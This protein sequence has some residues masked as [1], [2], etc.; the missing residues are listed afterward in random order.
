M[1]FKIV[2]AVEPFLKVFAHRVLSPWKGNHIVDSDLR[3]SII[4]WGFVS[5]QKILESVQP[6][7][8]EG[9]VEKRAEQLNLD[10]VEFLRGTEQA[11]RCVASL[12]APEP[13][14]SGAIETGSADQGSGSGSNSEALSDKGGGIGSGIAVDTAALKAEGSVQVA[15]SSVLGGGGGG[16]KPPEESRTNFLDLDVASPEMSMFLNDV[17]ESYRLQGLVPRLSISSVQASLCN[18]GIRLGGISKNT[19]F[20][21]FISADEVKYH[22]TMGMLGPEGAVINELE[23]RAPQRVIADVKLTCKEEFLLEDE[24]GEV[25]H[26]EA[27]EEGPKI[28][29]LTL[30]S[31]VGDGRKLQWQITNINDV[32]KPN[33]AYY[34]A[35]FG[36]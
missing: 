25:V 3:R 8:A 13:A 33:L 4:L 5:Q 15:S 32:I 2:R 30:Q 26:R 19:N 11:Y 23:G 1:F 31:N 18:V 28:H 7:R 20:L 27:T 36:H 17:L 9:R 14:S 22:L 10:T 6:H 12:F 24:G 29:F 21:G 16:K 35:R 34:F